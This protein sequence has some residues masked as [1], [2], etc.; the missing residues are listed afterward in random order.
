MLQKIL[1]PLDGSELAEAVLPYVEEICRRCEP[2]EVI[3]LQVIPSPAG[4]SGAVFQSV[5]NDFPTERLPYSQ[6]DV[7]TAQH[8]IYRGQE[9]ASA[10]AEVEAALTPVAQRLCDGGMP[11]RVAVAFGLPADEIVDL[12]VMSTHGHSGLSRWVFGSVAEKV[13]RA[14]AIP[15]L[16]IRPPGADRYGQ[17]PG[18]EL[19]L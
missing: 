4:R 10:Q 17:L 1:V 19:K 11:T 2:V 13:L 12:I 3:L 9:M 14:I 15:I 18:V 5:I 6:A 8:P 7:E 16:L